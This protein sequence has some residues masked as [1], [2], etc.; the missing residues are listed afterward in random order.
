MRA[1]AATR[2]SILNF[3]GRVKEDEIHTHTMVGR[4]LRWPPRFLPPG[5]HGL[6]N[7]LPSSRGRTCEYDGL[8]LVIMVYYVA[9][10]I[11]QM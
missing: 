11:V 8:S 10:G 6:C 9:K 3:Q 2:N 7:P 5:I 4:M 1:S